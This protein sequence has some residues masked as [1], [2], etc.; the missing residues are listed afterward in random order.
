MPRVL[1]AID[2]PKPTSILMFQCPECLIVWSWFEGTMCQTGCGSSKEDLMYDHFG[3]EIGN[4]QPT[5]TLPTGYMFTTWKARNPQRISRRIQKLL[6]AACG[7][8][9]IGI[10]D[11]LRMRRFNC[12]DLV[13]SAIYQAKTKEKQRNI[14]LFP[15][16]GSAWASDFL[17]EAVPSSPG[18]PS[19]MTPVALDDA[20]PRVECA[21]NVDTS[22]PASFRR[23]L[24]HLATVEAPIGLNGFREAIRSPSPKRPS[25]RPSVAW[26]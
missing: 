19:K 21:E 8:G 3:P 10:V 13:F 6:E 23:D 18:A 5:F 2:I 1:Y 14:G 17:A 12:V 20:A 22:T 11:N 16:L 15:S 25:T 26:I 7:R 9:A 24:I 4:L